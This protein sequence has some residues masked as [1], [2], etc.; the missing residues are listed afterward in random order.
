MFRIDYICNNWYWLS[1]YLW[2]VLELYSKQNFSSSHQN[3]AFPVVMYRGKNCTIKKAGSK[4]SMFLTCGAGEDSWEF[5]EQQED[6]T[7]QS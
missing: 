1:V 4:E 3:M 6:Q 2:H 5:L 7:S